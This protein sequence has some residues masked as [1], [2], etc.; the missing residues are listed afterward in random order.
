MAIILTSFECADKYNGLKFSVA[1]FQPKGSRLKTIPC[2][3]PIDKDGEAISTKDH[4]SPEAYKVAVSDAYKTRWVEIADWLNSLKTEVDIVLVCWCPYSK[5]Q[6]KHLRHTGNFFCHTGLIGQL[7]QKHRPDIEV[8]LDEDR[9]IALMQ[10]FKPEPGKC[11]KCELFIPEEEQ[12]CSWAKY[13]AGP[14]IVEPSGRIKSANPE[15]AAF[16]S[17]PE[18]VTTTIGGVTILKEKEVS[19]A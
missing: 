3:I 11:I 12:T 5:S 9:E 8:I 4:P 10:E 7:I 13:C 16:L 14:Y 6:E 18:D 2:L 15:Y 1:R 19:H 17:T